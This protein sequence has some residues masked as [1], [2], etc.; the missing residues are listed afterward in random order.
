MGKTSP[1]MG[2]R[3]GAQRMRY[4]TKDQF[5][6]TDLVRTILLLTYTTKGRSSN[7]AVVIPAAPEIIT[8]HRGRDSP[9]RAR[10]A[11]DDQFVTG[12]AELPRSSYAPPGANFPDVDTSA[13]ITDPGAMTLDTSD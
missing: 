3:R 1:L 6:T 10:A 7:F 5:S 2:Q 4:E 9:A 13:K 8:P 12:K 11:R